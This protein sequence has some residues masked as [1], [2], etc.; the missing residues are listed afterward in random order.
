MKPIE[1]HLYIN[2]LYPHMQ[3]IYC[4]FSELK[5]KKLIRLEVSRSSSYKFDHPM[6]YVIATVNGKQVIYETH[7]SWRYPEKLI[8]KG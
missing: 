2:T 3:Q 1:C 7:D 6:P 4:G 5:R 8:Q